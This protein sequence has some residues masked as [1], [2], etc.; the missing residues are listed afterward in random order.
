MIHDGLTPAM[1]ESLS[2]GI[3]KWDDFL[4]FHYAV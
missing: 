1:I 3:W 2:D 4:L